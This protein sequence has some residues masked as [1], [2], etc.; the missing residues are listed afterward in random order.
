MAQTTSR[1]CDTT[2]VEASTPPSTQTAK[3]P[4]TLASEAASTKQNRWH[5]SPTEKSSSQD[6][7]VLAAQRTLWLFDT[8]PVEASTQHSTQTAKSPPTSEATP[9]TKHIQWQY[10]QTE[11]SSSQE[12]LLTTTMTSRS[13][14]TT[15]T[16][17][18]TPPSIQTAKSPPTS[19]T[20]FKTRHIR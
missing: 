1:S 19:A 12:F 16:E 10:N 11:R 3:S 17:A 9:T 7:P 18:S 20:I 14:D 6:E 4:P 15:P 2:P 5:C 8:T 13:C